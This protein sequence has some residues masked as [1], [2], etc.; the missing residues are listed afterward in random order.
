MKLSTF[1][2]YFINIFIKE[3][4]N[5]EYSNI[6]YEIAQKDR[7]SDYSYSTEYDYYIQSPTISLPDKLMEW[8]DI[9][10]DIQVTIFNDYV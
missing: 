7:T 6:M 3:I 10:E 5:K 4:N 1:L 2:L 9:K 8:L